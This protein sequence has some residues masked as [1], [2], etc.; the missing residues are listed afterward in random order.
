MTRYFSPTCFACREEG[1]EG[2]HNGLRRALWCHAIL[3]KTVNP[4][5]VFCAKDPDEPKRPLNEQECNEITDIISTSP[6]KLTPQ[7]I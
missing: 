6:W 4:L 3:Y 1:R 2:W 5:E 7:E